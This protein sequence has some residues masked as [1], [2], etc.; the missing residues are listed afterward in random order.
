[1][2]IVCVCQMGL[3][4]S[5]MLKMNIEKVC[6][7]LG[8]EVKVDSCTAALAKSLIDDECEMV[9]T[10]SDVAPAVKDC[11]K[12]IVELKNMVSKKELTEKLQAYFA[13]KEEKEED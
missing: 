5:V 10:S 2:K 12:P 11:G 8:I 7:D 6:K 4:S 1:M 9:I 13:E 3:G